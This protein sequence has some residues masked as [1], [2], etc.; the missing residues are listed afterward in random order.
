VGRETKQADKWPTACPAVQWL[1]RGGLWLLTC[2]VWAAL[3]S[4]V[5]ARA[6]LQK[7]ADRIERLAAVRAQAAIVADLDQALGP[8]V[9]E[10]AADER[11]GGKCPVCPHVAPAGLEPAGDLP[12]FQRFKAVVGEGHAADGRGEG[13]D[14]LGAGARRLTRRPPGLLPDVGGHL[15][16][17]AGYG[18]GVPQRA[19]EEFGARADR[20]KP[21][22]IAGREP[23]GALWRQGSTGHEIMAMRMRG[24]SPRPGVQDP[25][26]AALSAAALGGHGQG[27]QSGSGGLEAQ[28]IQEVWVSAGP[29]PQCLGQCQGDQN[30]GD[31]QEPLALRV[32][33]WDSLGSLA[34]GTMPIWAGMIAVLRFTARHALLDMPASGGS[35]AVCNGRHGLSGARGDAV[36]ECGAILRAI[37]PDDVRQLEPGCAPGAARGLS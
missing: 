26:Q 27:F 13:S 11:G 35:P 22:T 18:Q 12:V 23:L 20:D 25:H 36:L 9:W 34:L 10:D 28:V 30:I 33:P 31:G 7:R 8:H 6:G 17:Q 2:L 29:W 4:M 37:A 21:R 5:V 3:P 32:Q 19:T 1:L 14:D 16:E 24:H 15:S